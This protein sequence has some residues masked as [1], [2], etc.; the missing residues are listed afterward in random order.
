MQSWS[1]S[2]DYRD[3]PEWRQLASVSRRLK[4]ASAA[5]ELTEDREWLRFV[6]GEIADQMTNTM[7]W[8]EDLKHRAVGDD[9]DEYAVFIV[10]ADAARSDVVVAT[11]CLDFIIA[12][13]LIDE[14]KG[15]E[16]R[17]QLN[18]LQKSLESLLT[19]LRNS[20]VQPSPFANN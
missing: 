20:Q 9:P 18:G 12:E 5:L 13:G 19:S 3:L 11:Y 1:G 6:L 7:R 16:L 10:P 8:A 15:T 2:N 17:D 4:E 14:T